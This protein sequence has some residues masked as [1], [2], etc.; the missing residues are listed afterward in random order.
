MTTVFTSILS[1]EANDPI[2]LMLV[3][4]IRYNTKRQK[5]HLIGKVH[6]L[7]HLVHLLSVR[8]VLR[9]KIEHS[10]PILQVLE[11]KELVKRTRNARGLDDY[12]KFHLHQHSQNGLAS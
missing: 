1:E 12:Q 6:I 8:N 10:F 9:T 11:G 4:K 5:A 7:K 3:L 2:L